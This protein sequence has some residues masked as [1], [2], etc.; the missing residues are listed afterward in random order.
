M[1]A[2]EHRAGSVVELV[3]VLR[4]LG[5]PIRLQIV[6]ILDRAE[7]AIACNEL[8]IPVSKSTTSHHLKLLR[9]AGVVEATVRGT[10]H[11]YTVRKGYL[12]ERFP[13]LLESVLRAVPS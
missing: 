13:G 8:P 6:C 2:P 9:E 5:D 10:R 12:A 11:Y 1:D 7:G 3:G 4:A